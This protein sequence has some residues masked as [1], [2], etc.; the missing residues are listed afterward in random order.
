MIM[1]PP[2]AAC[3]DLGARIPIGAGEVLYLKTNMNKRAT[4]SN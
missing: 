2:P 1:P 3:A 4:N